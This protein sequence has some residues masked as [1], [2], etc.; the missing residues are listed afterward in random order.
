MPYHDRKTKRLRRGA[1]LALL[2]A[3]SVVLSGAA[4]GRAEQAP[5]E[6]APPEPSGPTAPAELTP[7]EWQIGDSWVVET[8]TQRVQGREAAAD[9]ETTRLKWQFRVAKIE[10]VAG[11]D[12]YR[13]D[14]KC[15][16]ASRVR[17]QGTIWCDKQTLFLRQF[18][19]QVAFQGRYRTIQESYACA[20]GATAPVVTFVN[21]LP[22]AMPAFP[23][24]GAKAAGT[25]RYTSQ[26]LPAGAKDPGTVRFLHASTQQVRPAGAKALGAIPP[27]YAKSL[28]AGPLTE[29]TIEDRRE[30]VR[31]LW[32]PGSPW[33]VYVEN[34]RTEAWLVSTT[35]SE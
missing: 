35:R 28:G 9:P 22:L 2:A 14:I 30:S 17:P 4:G 6:A 29:V 15:L 27:N 12:C 11:G 10:K 7:P 33:P 19:T 31:Q 21:V 24:E 34:A 5:G 13:V 3:G 8:L 32:Q 25:F 16:A 26:P 23:P 1:C 20:K 18:Q